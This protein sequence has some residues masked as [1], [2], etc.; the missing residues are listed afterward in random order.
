[1]SFVVV[2]LSAANRAPTNGF[3]KISFFSCFYKIKI[4]IIFFKILR[5]QFILHTF[6][7]PQIDQISQQQNFHDFWN[8][9][10]RARGVAK[11]IFGTPML[12]GSRFFFDSHPAWECDFH[13]L[14]HHPSEN[15]FF[16]FMFFNTSLA[17]SSTMIKNATFEPLIR[18][19]VVNDA[20]KK[21]SQNLQLPLAIAFWNAI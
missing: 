9:R 6:A 20:V 21:S 5:K 1:M 15:A 7:P 14:R 2:T 12:H 16:F 13:I 17:R 10:S 11:I 3:N 19:H 8:R 18:R 4:F